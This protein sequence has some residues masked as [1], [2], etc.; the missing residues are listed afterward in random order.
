MSIY[1]R[2]KLSEALRQ[3]KKQHFKVKFWNW[4]SMTIGHLPSAQVFA[5]KLLHPILYQIATAY[6]LYL[7]LM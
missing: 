5:Q 1:F 2:V 6:A 4:G 7:I 3:V